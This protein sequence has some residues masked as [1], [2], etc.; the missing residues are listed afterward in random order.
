MAAL[1]GSEDGSS[2]NTGSAQ[3]LHREYTAADMQLHGCVARQADG[4]LVGKGC[5]SG[6]VV[7]GPYVAAPSSSD[8]F[9]KFDIES[10]GEL[11]LTSDVISGGAKQFHAAVEDQAVQPRRK[12]T[13]QYRVHLFDA[14]RALET[15]IGVRAD[16]ATD[17]VISD[18]SV[19][20]Q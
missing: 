5:P 8:L 10:S 2:S 3:G 19:H 1:T 18:L 7:F 15:R 16:G 17:F 20:I 4:R 13:I 14:A 6:I 11:R 12:R 9:L